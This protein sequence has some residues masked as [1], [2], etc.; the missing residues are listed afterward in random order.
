MPRRR[1][2]ITRAFE[3]DYSGYVIEHFPMMERENK[4]LARKF[5][6]TIDDTVEYA[7]SHTIDDDDY[8]IM[9]N[10][11]DFLGVGESDLL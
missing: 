4:R 2:N 8:R 5:A 6:D 10:N 7:E 9:I 1:K 3:M 11:A